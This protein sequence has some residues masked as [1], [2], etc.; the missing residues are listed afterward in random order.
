LYF[1]VLIKVI[2]FL[3]LRC[4]IVRQQFKEKTK[5]QAQPKLALK[6]IADAIIPVPPLEEQKRI[7]AK[8]DQLM[9]LCEELEQRQQKRRE[10]CVRLNNVAI[11][12]LLTTRET[13]DFSKHWQRICDNFDLRIL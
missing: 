10:S 6:R 4:D 13:D 1:E 3:A 12:Q 7:V 9:A 2:F 8:V 11:E 5:Q